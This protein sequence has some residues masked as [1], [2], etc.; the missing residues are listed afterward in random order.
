MHSFSAGCR[1]V[2]GNTDDSCELTIQGEERYCPNNPDDR[3]CTEFLHGK[4]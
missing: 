1:S 4:R 2:E 3:A